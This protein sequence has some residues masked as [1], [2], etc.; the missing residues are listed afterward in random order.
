MLL[1]RIFPLTV[2][3]LLLIVSC[4]AEGECD[5]SADQCA[6]P[7][8]VSEPEGED[9]NCPS[10]PY[11]IRCAAEYLDTN[12]NGKLERGELQS[13][14]DS[15]PWFSRGV[16]QILGSVDKM[17]KKCDM[18]GDDAI[19]IDEDMVKNKDQCLATCFKRK[20]KNEKILKK[21]NLVICESVVSLRTFLF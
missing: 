18:D 20:G 13:A 21:Q 17:M 19:S 7:E 3:F 9:P 1:R 8:T 16:I 5:A 6:N 10:R 4:Y 15:L 12:K 11:V 2:L 14:I